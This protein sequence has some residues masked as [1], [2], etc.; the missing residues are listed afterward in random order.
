MY[1][2]TTV[3]HMYVNYVLFLLASVKDISKLKHISG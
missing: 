1:V 2:G 3:Y